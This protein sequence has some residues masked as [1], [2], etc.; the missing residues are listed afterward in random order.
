M[1]L[2]YIAEKFQKILLPLVMYI[3]IS[4]SLFVVLLFVIYICAILKHARDKRYISR[5]AVEWQDTMHKLLN[6]E[7]SP[8]DFNLPSKD[9]KYFKD[10]L[11][12]EFSKQGAE[13]KSRLKDTYKYLGFFDED[14]RQLNSAL[15]WK[16]TEAAEKLGELEMR[17]A[18]DEVLPLLADRRDEV[19][20]SA[21]KMLASIHSQRLFETLPKVFKESRWWSY[22]YLVNKL[23][24]ADV[25]AANLKPLAISENRGFRKAAAILMG[26]KGNEEAIPLMRSLINDKIKDVRR[27]A[28]RALGKIGL[29]ETIPI[30]SEKVADNNPQV[31]AAVADAL[32]QLKDPGVL[33]LLEKLAC[34]TDFDVRFRAFFALDRLG[35]E[36]KTII[37]KYKDKYP[38]ITK[39]FLS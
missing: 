17:E 33:I 32:G 38:E 9:R 5:R 10:I 37:G 30:L 39:E 28:V 11:I 19:R 14:I 15:W 21:L 7:L 3:L 35:R 8:K 36:G 34:D 22:R 20:F 26:R 16:K 27:E 6:G 13:G 4:I 24:L 31:R 29:A 1:K 18:E 2:M 12:A 23:L 25:P